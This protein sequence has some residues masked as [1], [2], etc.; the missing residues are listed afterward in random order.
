MF[1]LGQKPYFT[2]LTKAGMSRPERHIWPNLLVFLKLKPHKKTASWM[3]REAV[4]I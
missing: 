4:F 1:I 2:G 3:T